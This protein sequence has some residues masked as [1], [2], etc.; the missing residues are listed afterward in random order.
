M[1]YLNKRIKNYYFT[2]YGRT[3]EKNPDFRCRHA[4]NGCKAKVTLFRSCTKKRIFSIIGSKRH[5]T[6]CTI[7]KDQEKHPSNFEKTSWGKIISRQN[8]QKYIIDNP[9]SSHD[10]RFLFA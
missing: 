6:G 4:K 10:K 3:K 7:V 5:T 2:D 9:S 8:I 1:Q